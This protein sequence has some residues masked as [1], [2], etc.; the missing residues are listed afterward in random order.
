MKKYLKN[1]MTLGLKI[2]KLYGEMDIE[3]PFGRYKVKILISENGVG[4]TNT[5]RILEAV[6]SRK[7]YKLTAFDFKEIILELNNDEII[8]RKSD[9]EEYHI[10][11]EDLPPEISEIQNILTESNYKNLLEY[12]R[13]LLFEDLKQNPL[14]IYT[15]KKLKIPEHHLAEIL[16]EFDISDAISEIDEKIA[17]LCTFD[18]LYLPTFRR[19]E[20][21]LTNL[22][23]DSFDLLKLDMYVRSG[24]QDIYSNIQERLDNLQNILSSFLSDTDI[25]QL[26]ITLGNFLNIAHKEPDDINFL[27]TVIN[28]LGKMISKQNIETIVEQFAD[29]MNSADNQLDKDILYDHLSNIYRTYKSRKKQF[30]YINNFMKVCNK[31]LVDKQIVYNKEKNQLDI[32]KE[33]GK[34][35]DSLDRLSSGEKQIISLFARLYFEFERPCFFIIDE[36]ENSMSIEWQRK[37]LPDI[38]KTLR[39]HCIVAATHSPFIFDNSLAMYAVAL[40]EYIWKV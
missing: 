8:I 20:E 34:P 18:V 13:L 23:L 4:K 26:L 39:C 11:P 12:S 30:E 31:Y 27:E 37:L 19:I 3:I 14:L 2:H 22:G 36:P 9:L 29:S 40:D 38:L 28:E 15:A 25:L 24:M 7:F 32:L 10:V 33:G 35:L 16:K 17:K 6:L 1:T 5:L 21:D